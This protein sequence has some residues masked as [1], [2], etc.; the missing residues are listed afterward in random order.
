MRPSFKQPEEPKDAQGFNARGNR[1]SRNG[2]YEPAL[3][4]IPERLNWTPAL[5]RLITTL[6]SLTTNWAG[7]LRLSPTLLGLLNSIPRMIMPTVV[8]RWRTYLVTS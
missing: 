8:A 4:V 2:A 3:A 7:M 1:Y 6:A 5:L